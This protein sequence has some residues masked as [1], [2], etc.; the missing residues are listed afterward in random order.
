[1]AEN[2]ELAWYDSFSAGPD[3]EIASLRAEIAR[4]EQALSEGT[5]PPVPGAAEEDVEMAPAAGAAAAAAP[6]PAAGAEEEDAEMAPAAGAGAAPP[7]PR[8]G[9]TAIEDEQIASPREANVNA[10]IKAYNAIMDVARN[11]IQTLNQ[12]YS[13]DQY[14]NDAKKSLVDKYD[15]IFDDANL[16]R[17][18]YVDTLI[19]LHTT[20]FYTDDSN[21]LIVFNLVGL[22]GGR[23]K[24]QYVYARDSTPAPPP[25]TAS[26]TFEAARAIP[27][28]IMQFDPSDNLPVARIPIHGELE[29]ILEGMG[30][31]TDAAGV[32]P[33]LALHVDPAAGG[34]GEGPVSLFERVAYRHKPVVC[35]NEQFI[36]EGAAAA[37][38]AAAAAGDVEMAVPLWP[39]APIE[40]MYMAV[41]IVRSYIDLYHD[42]LGLGAKYADQIIQVIVNAGAIPEDIKTFVRNKCDAYKPLLYNPATNEVS[43]TACKKCTEELLDEYMSFLHSNE[44]TH[45]PKTRADAFVAMEAIAKI[46]PLASEEQEPSELLQKLI[47]EH[48]VR[49][50]YVESAN[51]DIG[52]RLARL[53]PPMMN[54]IMEAG[55]WDAGSGYSGGG[56]E[57][58]LDIPL[59]PINIFGIYTVE[60]DPSN[61]AIRITNRLN[62]GCVVIKPTRSKRLS[63]NVLLA[64]INEELVR[65]D[66]DTVVKPFELGTELTLH[67]IDFDSAKPMI[68]ALKTWTDYMQVVYASFAPDDKKTVFIASDT[69]CESAARMMGLGHTLKAQLNLVSYFSYDTRSRRISDDELQAKDVAYRIM[70]REAT[71]GRL[72]TYIQNWFD[73]RIEAL[74]RLRDTSPDPFEYCIGEFFSK[75]IMDISAGWEGRYAELNGRVSPGAVATDYIKQISQFPSTFRTVLNILT[76]AQEL[77]TELQEMNT[78]FVGLAASIQKLHSRSSVSDFITVYTAIKQQIVNTF[79]GLDKTRLRKLTAYTIV[80]Y[81][82]AGSPR[83]DLFQ[84]MFLNVKQDL[85]KGYLPAAEVAALLPTSGSPA[86][87]QISTF[88]VPYF[89]DVPQHTTLQDITDL[90][91]L[92]QLRPEEG[93]SAN[94]IITADATNAALIGDSAHAT[95]DGPP[96]ADPRSLDARLK[97]AVA[98]IKAILAEKRASAEYQ[99]SLI[100]DKAEDTITDINAARAELEGEADVPAKYAGKAVLQ[101]ELANHQTILEAW[102]AQLASYQNGAPGESLSQTQQRIAGAMQVAKT[103]TRKSI[104]I[105]DTIA[106]IR[107]AIATTNARNEQKGLIKQQRDIAIASLKLA[108]K[109]PSKRAEVLDTA[110]AAAASAAAA[111]AS[112]LPNAAMQKLVE[113]ANAAVAAIEALGGAAAGGGG[114]S[115]VS[116]T[117]VKEAA[118]TA[119][120][121]AP[122]ASGKALR[123]SKAWE[124]GRTQKLAASGPRAK[125]GVPGPA[126]KGKTVMGPNGTLQPVGRRSAKGAA[127]TSYQPPSATRPAAGSAARDA[128]IDARRRMT[129]KAAG[130]GGGGGFGARRG[131]ARETRRRKQRRTRRL[132]ALPN[133]AQT[134]RRK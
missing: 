19:N 42:I 21:K 3:A 2:L 10:I 12:R 50:F 28:H 1:M 41:E 79:S 112:A 20:K 51:S 87:V 131:G 4:Y 38:A 30:H 62:D 97:A 105:A 98:K 63:V 101:R 36:G 67:G 40:K 123:G 100:K 56:T 66:E 132:R 76:K 17:E 11:A 102:M 75:K 54:T 121:T 32:E 37:G 43:Q 61:T 110:R 84:S 94:T 93:T 31:L 104:D 115:K 70:K 14:T 6:A 113:Q 35:G 29:N 18:L 8:V 107:L 118:L 106:R 130:A 27:V 120:R 119:V 34:V 55:G 5:A 73:V 78:I 103:I 96:N 7:D 95:P 48:S 49:R 129:G 16:S 114:R 13:S 9:T 58:F 108:E 81:L 68:I 99:I 126:S 57:N 124:E 45:V 127:T 128:M 92:F 109:Y 22:G 88:S 74:Q 44:I 47:T 90:E 125:K 25:A 24:W 82:R 64:T 53:A 23:P 39:V 83:A 59:P 71:S 117:P 86:D 72:S 69:L 26:I 77:S 91:A 111:A 60:V 52:P 15:A 65:G 122:G 134:R 85:F 80:Y 33:N 133:R 89:K 46:A 116:L